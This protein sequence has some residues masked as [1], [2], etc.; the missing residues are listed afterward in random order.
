MVDGFVQQYKD[1]GWISRWSSPGYA[2]LMTG[3]SLGRRLRRRVRQG[4]EAST[5][6]R[7]TTRPLKNATVVPPS[8][9]RRPQGHGDLALPRLHRHRDPRGPVLGAGGLPQRLRHRADG[10]GALQEDRRSAATRRSREYFLDRARNYVKL[11]DDEAGFFQ[12]RDAERRLARCRRRST[13]RA[14]GATTT[15][16][17]TA[18]ATPSPPRRTAGAWPTSTA[19]ATGLAKKLDKYFST[20]ET[21][22]QEFAGSYGGRHPRD[23]RGT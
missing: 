12:G 19:G 4:R 17:P 23:D 15:P 10:P 18:G 1:G 11:F 21:A 7:R 14:S 22:S 2:D 13:T 5:R 6:R 20:P 9:G 8:L 3:T 16:R